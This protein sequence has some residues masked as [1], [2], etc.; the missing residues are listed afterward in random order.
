MGKWMAVAAL[1]FVL[2]GC[3]FVGTGAPSGPPEIEDRGVVSDEGRVKRTVPFPEAE[4][5]KLDKRGNAT[6]TG[7]LFIKTRAGDSVYG[8]DEIVSV[9]PATTYAAE[10][11]EA[12]LAG[13]RLEP[14]DPRAK[15]YTH[16]ARTDSRGYFK[17]SGLPDGVFYIG[18]RVSVPGDGR[19]AVIK[20]VRL[21]KGETKK[22]QLSR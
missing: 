19:R 17:V 10:A 4:Y 16:Y 3:Q 21:D 9:A 2:T 12:A 7:Q 8:A 11:A 13:K 1:G 6:I 20:Q 14:A 5:A 22:I 15:E 18:G